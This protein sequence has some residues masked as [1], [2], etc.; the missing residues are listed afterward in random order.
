MDT[1]GG[2]RWVENV[3]D[4]RVVD[5]WE[6]AGA[7]VMETAVMAAVK[8]TEVLMAWGGQ[9]VM[10]AALVV[11]VMVAVACS[12]CSQHNLQTCT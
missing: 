8:E 6:E 5:A 4:L 1:Q 10:V 7:V 3:V 2:V 9:V 11:V 12:S